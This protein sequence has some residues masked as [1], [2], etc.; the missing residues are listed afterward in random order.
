[1]FC[2]FVS[3][4]SLLVAVACPRGAISQIVDCFD[5]FGFIIWSSSRAAGIRPDPP[6]KRPE[7]DLPLLESRR[8]QGS[9]R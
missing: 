2:G 5:C 7:I 9:Y 6:I 4:S 8:K 3:A 1:M